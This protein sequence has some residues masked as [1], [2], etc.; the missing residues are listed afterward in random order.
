[1]P[2][3]SLSLMANDPYHQIGGC[4]GSS[5][6][7]SLPVKTFNVFTSDKEDAVFPSYSPEKHQHD[8][9]KLSDNEFLHIFTRKD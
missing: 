5:F 3:F 8:I 6:N 1:M 2:L 9:V 4:C 7:S